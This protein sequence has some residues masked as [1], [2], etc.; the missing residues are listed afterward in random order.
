M[1]VKIMKKIELNQDS[2]LVLQQIEEMGEEDFDS[3][4]ESL[5]FGRPYLTHII[6]SLRHKGLV[7]IQGPWITLS[8]KGRK[9]TE[10][11]WP[12]MDYLRY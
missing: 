8:S 7:K 10:V 5:R 3:L 2:A 9:T 4:N 6:T 12:K 11:I 1:E